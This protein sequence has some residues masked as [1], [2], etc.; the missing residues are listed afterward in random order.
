MYQ[1]PETRRVDHVDTYHGVEVADPYRWLEDDPRNSEEIAAW[2]E[3]QNSVTRSHLDAI[4]ARREFESRLTDLWNYERYSV[5][6]EK[7]GKYFFSKNDGLQNQS[8]LYWSNAYNGEPRVLINPN[9]WSEDGTVALGGGRV[10]DDG[11]YFAFLRKESGS[12]WSTIRVVEI[13][14]GNELK[15]EL[16]WTRWGNIVWNADA[17]GFF[18]IRYPEPEEGKKFLASAVNPM[19][20]FHKLGEDQSQD[21]FVYRDQEHPERSFYLQRS[22]DDQYL[23][24]STRE[25]TDDQ[26]LVYVRPVGSPLDGEWTRLIDDFEN[27]FSFLGNVEEVFYFFTDFEAPT[28]RIVAM[29]VNQP[30]RSDLEEIVPAD[31]ATLSGASMLKDQIIC[32]YMKDVVSQ[33]KVFGYEGDEVSEVELPGI[34]TARGFGGEQKDTETFFSFTSYVTPPSIYRYDL[35]SRKIEQIRAP[36]VKFDPELYESRQAFYTSKDGTR[37]PIIVSHRKGLEA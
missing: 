16:L 23:V 21:Q 36:Q 29:N 15:D 13:E 25:G 34:G 12:D 31:E 28:K 2:L 10:S 5:P 37:V 7:A 27:E 32:H 9:E 11:K 20:Y 17:T 22:E 8:V 4:G 26:N 30:G 18:Y 33:V 24:L 1:Y 6:Y 35:E 14:S 19:I 3:A